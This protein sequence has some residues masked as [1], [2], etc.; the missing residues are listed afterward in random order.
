MFVQVYIWGI[1]YI[2]SLHVR[3]GFVYVYKREDQLGQTPP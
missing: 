2:L 1:L 3:Y